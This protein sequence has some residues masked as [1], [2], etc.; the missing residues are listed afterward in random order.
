MMN[1]RGMGLF[2]MAFVLL[3]LVVGYAVSQQADFDIDKFKNNLTWEDK[4]FIVESA[5]DLG[6]A[7]T[8]LV[9]GLG[10][11]SFSIA[12]WVAQWSADNPNVPWKF[13]II[14]VI[15]SVLA[16]LILALVKLIAVLFI[17]IKDF[18]QS[19]KDKKEIERLRKENE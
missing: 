18:I 13:L 12:K 6:A 2:M 16:P 4:T 3:A 7:L 5:P 19:R 1:K 11:A 17:L 10:S 14:I 15:L 8:D 9:N